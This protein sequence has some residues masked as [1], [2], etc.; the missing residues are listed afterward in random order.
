[1]I[2]RVW[3]GQTR[4]EDADAYERYLR[5]TGEADCRALPGNRGVLILRGE[6]EGR[7]EFV[8]VS[9]WDSMDAVRAFS[10]SDPERARYYPQDERYLLSLD[11]HVRHY[12][13][14]GDEPALPGAA[15]G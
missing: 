9:F 1:M 2:A 11:P 5:E 4:A 7:A 6:G 12:R 10:G 3:S 13:V 14:A 15:A 8:F